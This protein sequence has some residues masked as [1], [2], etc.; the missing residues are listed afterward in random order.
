M[1]PLLVV[2]VEPRLGR[3]PDLAERLEDP[4]VQ[5]TVSEHSAEALVVAVL[6]ETA[7]FDV[8]GSDSTLF[9][10]LLDPLRDEPCAVVALDCDGASVELDELLEDAHDIHR[11]EVPGALDPEGLSGE[12]IDHR[13][14]ANASPFVRLA[15]PRVAPG[16]SLSRR[17]KSG[18]LSE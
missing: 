12:L 3:L 11:C 16:A 17:S 7:G 6:P 10:P 9:D 4:S 2:F 1:G 15:G 13:Q 14:E 18:R 8:P 5:A